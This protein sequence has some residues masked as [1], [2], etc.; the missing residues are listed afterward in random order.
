M[1]PV[2]GAEGLLAGA[3]GTD[4]E[5]QHNLW[6]IGGKDKR[7]SIEG[8]ESRVCL[9]DLYVVMAEIQMIPRESTDLQTQVKLLYLS[10]THVLGA[11][12]RPLCVT[13]RCFGSCKASVGRQLL[14]TIRYEIY[15]KIN[16]ERASAERVC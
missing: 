12:S 6:T 14:N 5:R 4:R 13:A 1:I 2:E 8:S 11:Q 9:I 3:N 15:S 16:A 10:I 7:R